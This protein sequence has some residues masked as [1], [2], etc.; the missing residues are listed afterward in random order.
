M[1]FLPIVSPDSLDSVSSA[2]SEMRREAYGAEP[3]HVWATLLGHP[4]SYQAY[5]QWFV[6]RDSVAP[7]IGDRAV[8]LFSYAISEGN[9]CLVWS[10]YF[11][12]AL[13]ESGENPESPSVTETEQLLIEWG[14][15]IAVRPAVIDSDFYDRLELA[16]S[17]TLR[18]ALLAFAGLTVALNVVTTV[19]KVQIDD[20][21]L[22][23]RKP[24]DQ[25][26]N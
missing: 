6:V 4:P 22:A 5:L 13:S 11:R 15:S 18:I 2:H 7:F 10:A 12:R 21:L 24:G 25:R 20:S 26:S 1:N 17:P 23:F 14:R 9:D 16:F 19:G 8:A 3:A